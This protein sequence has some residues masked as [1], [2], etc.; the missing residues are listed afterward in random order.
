MRRPDPTNRNHPCSWAGNAVATAAARVLTNY[1]FIRSA[2]ESTAAGPN[3]GP[4]PARSLRGGCD[5]LP[6]T[7]AAPTTSAV[8]VAPPPSS[9][10]DAALQPSPLEA[11]DLNA[12]ASSVATEGYYTAPPHS[13]TPASYATSPISGAG[14]HRHGFSSTITRLGFSD[15]WRA[16]PNSSAGVEALR[17]RQRDMGPL[18]RPNDNDSVAVAEPTRVSGFHDL[19]APLALSELPLLPYRAP[20]DPEASTSRGG[21][22]IGIG[23][24]DTCTVC[25]EEYADGEMLRVLPCQHRFHAHCLDCWVQ[26][27]AVAGHAR[28]CRCPNCNK[29]IALSG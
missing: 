5:P 6:A 28:S 20:R 16:P 3:D 13:Y 29:T 2:H 25:L 14:V 19:S 4:L 15:G 21:I 1:L 8:E 11:P 26:S 10:D 27:R 12:G 22:G 9:W 18:R 7:Q 17:L 23:I 24:G